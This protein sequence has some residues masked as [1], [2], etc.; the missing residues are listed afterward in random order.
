MTTLKFK[1]NI[2]CTGCLAKVSPLLDAETS[3]EKWEVDIFTPAKVLTITT[4]ETDVD[5][6]TKL[7][8]DTVGKAGFIVEEI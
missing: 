2:K 1:S 3:I 8:E 7:V 4:E 6:I 5:K